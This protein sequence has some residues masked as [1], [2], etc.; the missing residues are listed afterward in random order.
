VVRTGPDR[1]L[2]VQWLDLPYFDQAASSP[3][4]TITITARLF[5]DDHIEI[6]AEGDGVPGLFTRGAESFAGDM[7]MFLP[8][9]SRGSFS[10]VARAVEIATSAASDDDGSE[11]RAPFEVGDACDNYWVA[12]EASVAGLDREGPGHGLHRARTPRGG[13][14]AW[15]D[16]PDRPR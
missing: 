10:P 7:A 5:S 11:A 6:Q 13:G 16:V 14:G 8:G 9:E 1:E 4:G 2:Q 15:T 12:D 3:L